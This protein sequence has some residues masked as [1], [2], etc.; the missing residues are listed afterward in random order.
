[1]DLKF[2]SN[3]HIERK[4]Q[5]LIYISYEHSLQISY[6]GSRVDRFLMELDKL[7]L[8]FWKYHIKP[9]IEYS[10]QLIEFSEGHLVDVKLMARPHH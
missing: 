8:L 9:I 4:L 5:H 1:M 2:I 10:G 7:P 6:K 3:L